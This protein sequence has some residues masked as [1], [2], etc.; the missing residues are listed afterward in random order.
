[1]NK[2]FY[3]FFILIIFI[4]SGCKENDE[5]KKEMII[6]HKFIGK[7]NMNHKERSDT[8][9]VLSFHEFKIDEHEY[10][11]VFN[12]QN[13]CITHKANCQKCEVK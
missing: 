7:V 12:I 4:F 5:V 10:I 11:L 3:V 1:M 13:S 2:F 9:Y 6:N 8:I